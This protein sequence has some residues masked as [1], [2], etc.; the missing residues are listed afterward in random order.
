MQIIRALFMLAFFV[1]A[2][3]VRADLLV[4]YIPE[5]PEGGRK[6]KVE[7]ANKGQPVYLTLRANSGARVESYQ[8]SQGDHEV[9]INGMESSG[10]SLVIQTTAAAV[11]RYKVF[12]KD[13]IES[14]VPL[15]VVD[16][17]KVKRHIPPRFPGKQRFE[18]V[19]INLSETSS[20]FCVNVE[21]ENLEPFASAAFP[22]QSDLPLIVTSRGRDSSFASFGIVKE[23]GRAIGLLSPAEICDEQCIAGLSE[24]DGTTA[25]FDIMPLKGLISIEVWN[26]AAVP[27]EH[28]EAYATAGI[29]RRSYKNQARN[30]RIECPFDPLMEP[31]AA[32]QVYYSTK[33]SVVQSSP[34]AV[35]SSLVSGRS[36]FGLY[37]KDVTASLMLSPLAMLKINTPEIS[38]A[39]Y[40]A[41]GNAVIQSLQGFEILHPPAPQETV[42]L[43]IAYDL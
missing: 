9:E 38:F 22:A 11:C 28:I 26:Q 4:G 24:I 7:C 39:E 3:Y 14:I 29:I 6:I 40:R 32:F 23:Q 42:I 35:S 17:G 16:A 31:C 33:N 13:A 34:V 37:S 8:F 25:S 18:V 1:L 12:Y 27:E 15:R 10:G 19:V 43:P 20:E 2:G 5:Q 30:M 41:W 36:A 21:C